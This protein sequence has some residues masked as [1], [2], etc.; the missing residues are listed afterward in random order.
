M[1]NKIITQSRSRLCV[2]ESSVKVKE[3]ML[4]SLSFCAFD[5]GPNGIILSSNGGLVDVLD[6]ST[7]TYTSQGLG[8][9]DDGMCMA[10]RWIGSGY[11]AG[12]EDGSVIHW[13]NGV[14]ELLYLFKQPVMC[15]DFRDSLV[16]FA[17]AEGGL[18]LMDLNSEKVRLF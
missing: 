7:F 1:G 4:N 12:Y 15:I 14:G 8:S 11:I 9:G 5:L 17:S 3:V 13:Q 16:G 2:W 10:L 6:P 18:V